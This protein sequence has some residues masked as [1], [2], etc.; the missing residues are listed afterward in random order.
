MAIPV[1][2][3][4]KAFIQA[5]F[6]ND[7]LGTW[8]SPVDVGYTEDGV[9]PQRQKITVPVPSD[10]YGGQQGL[11]FDYQL[12]LERHVIRLALSRYDSAVT[13]RMWMPQS[14]PTDP[15]SAGFVETPGSLMFQG[16]RFF[17]L[18]YGNAT[19]G[20]VYP[21]CTLWL[22]PKEVNEGTRYSTCTVGVVAQ[23]ARIDTSGVLTYKMRYVGTSLANAWANL[24][25]LVYT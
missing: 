10:E 20:V 11:P 8:A 19:V 1:N 14:S 24:N 25:S 23:P 2:V 9:Q 6:F 13:E 17:R 12:M 22:E 5:S 7:N 16:N 21:K 3:F 4:G 15:P 18:C